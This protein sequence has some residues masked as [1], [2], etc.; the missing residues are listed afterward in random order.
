MKRFLYFLSLAVLLTTVSCTEKDTVI[1]YGDT[2]FGMLDNGKILTDNGVN[3]TVVENQSP[4]RMDTTC[5]VY[6]ICDI[7]NA[8]ASN[9]Y[10]IRLTNAAAV[11]TKEIPGSSTLPAEGLKDDP[12][13]IWNAW[14]GGG[15]LNLG[16]TFLIHNPA[17]DSHRINL[18]RD[19]SAGSGALKLRLYHDAGED[20][21]ANLALEEVGTVNSYV[22]FHLAPLIVAGEQTPLTLEWNWYTD[23][24]SL[25]GVTETYTLEG[26]IL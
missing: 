22:S 2:E 21:V 1:A 26:N 13:N 8:N 15:Y 25:D 24:E 19:E 17:K 7:L 11:L 10:D 3:L 9:G 18:I 16:V 5:R 6:I 12:I 14:Y 20:A 23:L 4:M